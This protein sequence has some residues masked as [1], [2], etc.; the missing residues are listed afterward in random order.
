MKKNYDVVIIG[1]GPAG[2]VAAIRCAQLG[3]TTACVDKWLDKNNHPK[4]GGTCLNVGCIPS[5]ALLE[6]SEVYHQSETLLAQHGINVDSVSL[7]L[8]KMMDRKESVVNTLTL[9]IESL[10]KSNKIDWIQGKATIESL[11]AEINKKTFNKMITIKLHNQDTQQINTNNIIIATGSSPVN[12]SIAPI[13]DEYIVD[14]T[15]A[16]AFK[17]VPEKLG[18][19]GSGVIGLEL[20]SVWKRLGAEVKIFEAQDSFLSFADEFIAKESLK[21]Y[22]QQGLEIKLN[23]RLLNAEVKNNTVQIKFMDSDGEHHEI[24]DKL[25]IAVGRE[26]NSEGLFNNETDLVMDEGGLIHVNEHC[27]TSLPGIY[28]IGD[29][30]RG[31]MLAHKGSEEGL[32][33][34]ELI[35]G[36]FRAVNYELIPSVIYTHPEIAWVG[37]TEQALRAAGIEY[38]VGTFPFAAS[39]RAQAVNQITG[40]IKVISHEVT[41]KILGVHILG[42]H[43][44]ELIA[45]AVIAMEFGASSED[46][47]LIMFAHPTFSEAFHEASLAVSGNALH[48]TQRKNIANS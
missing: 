15:G 2:Y 39:G 44:S 25:I 35:A 12:L 1:G 24:F 13:D 6:S 42:A 33:V 23:T 41:D 29:T 7:D 17:K 34:A 14:S 18:I 31:P 43:A 47:A 27:E 30:V 22:T 37:K 16:L 10:F 40:M 32:M 20:G 11:N 46:I 8:Q 45:Q 9:G 38:H 21:H 48:I 4:L 36:N 19:I 3:L 28:A 5:K 26:P